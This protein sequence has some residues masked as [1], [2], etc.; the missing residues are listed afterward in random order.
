MHSNF[1]WEIS[2]LLGIPRSGIAGMECRCMFSFSKTYQIFSH[3]GCAFPQFHSIWAF[4]LLSILVSTWD[5]QS[6][7][8][9]P[10]GVKSCLVVIS[11][12]TNDVENFFS[13]TYWPFRYS[14]WEVPLQV[15]WPLKKLELS[16]P[17]WY[18][19]ILYNSLEMFFARHTHCRLVLLFCCLL[20]QCL[21]TV[22]W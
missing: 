1:C 2:F 8:S 5:C 6:V 17:Y 11:L 21:G 16:F 14:L 12:M 4:Q 9:I 3:S 10:I 7:L 20:F 15:F 13:F 19:G 22:F 18:V